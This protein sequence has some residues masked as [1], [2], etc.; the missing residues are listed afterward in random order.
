MTAPGRNEHGG[1]VSTDDCVS[2]VREFA[3]LLAELKGRT[4]RSYGSLARHVGMNTSTLHRYCAGEA[5]PQDFAPVERLAR[6]CGATPAERLELHRRW[7]RAAA[8]RKRPRGAAAAEARRREETAERARTT[9]AGARGDGGPDG[10]DDAYDLAAAQATAT[11]TETGARARAGKPDAARVRPHRRRRRTAL[12][13][14]AA[15][16]LLTTLGTLSALPAGGHRHP[17]E[18][19]DA[20][21]SAAAPSVPFPAAASGRS[22]SAPTPATTRVPA[23]SAA[24]SSSPG[25]ATATSPVAEDAPAG[26]GAPAFPARGVPLTWTAD[27]QV[28]AQG[29]GHDYV[30]DRPP[31]Q[32]PPPPMAQDAGPWASAQGALHGRE[33]NVE[34]TLQGRGSSAVVLTAVRVRVTGRAAPARGTAY[35]MEQGCGGSL[36]RRYFAVDLDRDRPVARSVAGADEDRT[37]PAVRLPYRVSG[38]DPEVLLV[39]ARTEKCACDWYLELDWSSGGRSGTV[40]VDD[41]GRPFR[42]TGIKGLPRYWYGSDGGERRWVP[43]TD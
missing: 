12:L 2:D 9:P 24:P 21:R 20:A 37:I 41:H 36:S 6:F 42:T 10:V 22:S 31:A 11:G 33:T 27:S 16:A 38:R 29:C 34:I 7:L 18:R 26:G 1:T 25:R 30:I 19:D 8:A 3:A 5:V 35:A 14:G 15:C 4:E 32:V 28:W 40:R 17:S 13:V 39:T 23:R 43:A